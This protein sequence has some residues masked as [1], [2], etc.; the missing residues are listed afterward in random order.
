MKKTVAVIL[1]L[2][3]VFTL[4][5]CDTALKDDPRSEQV[6]ASL[7]T[8]EITGQTPAPEQDGMSVEGEFH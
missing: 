6:F 1:I 8:E 5:A 3:L 4:A 2:V 7:E